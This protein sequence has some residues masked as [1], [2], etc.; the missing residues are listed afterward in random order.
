MQAAKDG[1]VLGDF[2]G[3]TLLHRGKTWRFFRQGEK[4]MVHA[5]GPDG[6]DA[7]TSR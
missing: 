4:F 3:A 6:G 7:R 1:T 2:A 5:E